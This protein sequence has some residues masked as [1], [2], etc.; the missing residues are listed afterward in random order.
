M[1][2]PESGGWDHTHTLDINFLQKK[3]PS[4]EGPFLFYMAPLQD[5][6]VCQ[7]QGGNAGELEQ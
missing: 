6:K 3:G 1:A 5:F 4:I 7:R 2:T